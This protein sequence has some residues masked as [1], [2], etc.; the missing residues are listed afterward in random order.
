MGVSGN[1]LAKQSGTGSRAGVSAV[2]NRVC[3]HSGGSVK[4]INNPLYLVEMV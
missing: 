4:S 1:N 2:G 3:K